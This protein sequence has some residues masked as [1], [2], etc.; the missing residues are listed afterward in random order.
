MCHQQ[1]SRA[2]NDEFSQQAWQIQ[3]ETK[4][5]LY[6]QQPYIGNRSIG[7]NAVVTLC[8]AKKYKMVQES[9]NSHQGN[10]S[11]Q[12]LKAQQIPLQRT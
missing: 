6:Q 8:T 1:C 11:Q 12:R 2:N 9:W 10:F 4:R 5:R 3:K 7:S